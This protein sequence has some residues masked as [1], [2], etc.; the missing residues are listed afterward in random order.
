MSRRNRV[1][2]GGPDTPRKGAIFGGRSDSLKS[3]VSH[4]CGVRS[5]KSITASARLLQPVYY[6]FGCAM[7]T[8]ILLMTACV[9]CLAGGMRLSMLCTSSLELIV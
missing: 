1:L 6:Y 4:C 3:I 2:Y 7:V 9:V 5:K 8:V